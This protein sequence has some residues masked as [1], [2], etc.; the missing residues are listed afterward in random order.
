MENEHPPVVELSPREKGFV[1]R[2]LKK[3]PGGQH[4]DKDLY[5]SVAIFVLLIVL[6]HAVEQ[7]VPASMSWW[8]PPLIIL[9]PAVILFSRYRKFSIFR[10]CVL[11]KVAGRLAR[12]EDLTPP[13]G[14]GGSH[15]HARRAA[16]AGHPAA[17]QSSQ[18]A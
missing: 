6:A 10:S 15:P 12:Y 18:A 9:P 4:R 7:L 1:C 13:R 11:S 14:A 3:Y 5:R 16:G 2:I 8:L 17:E